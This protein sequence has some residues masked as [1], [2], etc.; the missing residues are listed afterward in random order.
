MGRQRSGD[1]GSGGRG[2]WPVRVVLLQTPFLLRG[3][4][5]TGII[6][7]ENPDGATPLGSPRTP[8]PPPGG[9]SEATPPPKAF[10]FTPSCLSPVRCFSMQL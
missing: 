4:K 3:E 6:H 9:A 8:A 1:A 7:C 10:L 5:C 2:G